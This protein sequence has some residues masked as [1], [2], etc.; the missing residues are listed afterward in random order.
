MT[1]VQER[2]LILLKEIDKICKDNNIIYYA[3]GGTVIGTL[4]HKGFIPWDDDVDIVFTRENW[5]KFYRIVS[6]KTPKNRK[7]ESI[8]TNDNYSM[9]YARYC[10][11]T[12]TSILLTSFL[13][14]FE[15]GV[16]IDMFILD[17]IP[18]EKEKTIEYIETLKGYCEYLNPYYYNTVVGANKWYDF[19]YE[20]GKKDGR[21]KVI[22]WMEKNRFNIDE[23]GKKN[24]LFRCDI[25]QFIYPI[26]LFGNPRY[27]DFEDMKIPVPEK[28]EEYLRIHY[29]FKWYELPNI[30]EQTGHN[31]II[32]VN[33]PYKEYYN[34]YIKYINYDEAINNYRELHKKNVEIE[35]KKI[36]INNIICNSICKYCIDYYNSKNDID[37]NKMIKQDLFDD[38]YEYCSNFIYK[39]INKEIIKRYIVINVDEKIIAA[40]Y[41]ALEKLGMHEIAFKIYEFRKLYANKAKTKELL[42]AE[43]LVN[44]ITNIIDAQQKQNKRE[45]KKHFVIKGRVVNIV[46]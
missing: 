32:N 37:L 21:S 45:I 40:S 26:N 8:Y 18:N 16:F 1:D 22:E 43:M 39:Q 25:C 4:R 15:S 44:D 41:V 23:K 10:D 24:Y 31:A 9:V 35:K 7:I 2:L 46:I 27:E 33:I 19:F 28:A 38:V 5:K 11:T 20:M 30:N 34:E 36:E 13:D 14:V 3:D 29:G 6:K 12:S 17:P 42:H